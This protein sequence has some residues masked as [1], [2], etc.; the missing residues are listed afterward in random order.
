MTTPTTVLALALAVLAFAP[1]ASTQAP[2]ARAQDAARPVKP[3]IEPRAERILKI[4]D[5]FLQSAPRIRFN[6]FVTQDEVLPSGQKIQ[7]SARMTLV[8]KRPNKVFV[9]FH[10]DKDRKMLWSDGTRITLY[11]PQARAY[12]HLPVPREIDDAVDKAIEEAGF[13]IP[14]IDLVVIDPDRPRLANVV[15]GHYVGL[16]RVRE[17]FCH[18]LA[19]AGRHLDWQ[20]WIEDG[21]KP[22]PRK[23]V[24]TYKSLPGSP[25][26]TAWIPT[27]DFSPHLPDFLFSFRPPPDAE[28][29]EFLKPEVKR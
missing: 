28:E 18:H 22:V 19:F 24:I 21:P 9:S 4:A 1:A 2:A 13:S 25:Q 7:Y 10:G 11:D 27:W 26:Y 23:V 14:L 29:I 3:K 15:S 20:I 12:A 16:H 17:T 8:M 5:D 6:A